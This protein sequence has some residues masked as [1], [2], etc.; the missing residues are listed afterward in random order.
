VDGP[1]GQRIILT[2]GSGEQTEEEERP[3]KSLAQNSLVFWVIRAGRDFK[4][5]TRGSNSGIELKEGN[6]GGGERR[7]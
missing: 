7:N 4:P 5:V 2:E 1:F 6:G 3:L